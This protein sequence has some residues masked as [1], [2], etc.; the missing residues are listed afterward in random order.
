MVNCGRRNG[1]LMA[2]DRYIGR[3]LHNMSQ[4]M[5]RVGRDGG[6]KNMMMCDWQL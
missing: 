1:V 5:D 3:G 4:S 6:E 2:H